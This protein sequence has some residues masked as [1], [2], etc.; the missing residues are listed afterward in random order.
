M[1]NKLKFLTKMSLKK[2]IKTKWF[3]A[4]NIII[5]ICIV[6]LL[7][8]DNIVKLFGGDFNDVTEILVI[9]NTSE[10]V[11]T[12][13]EKSYYDSS[14]YL[15]SMVN[16]SVMLYQNSE[17]EA[18]EEINADAEKILVIINDDPLN[19]L[20][21]Q[22][23][24]KSGV[25]AIISQIISVSLDAIKKD[26]ALQSLEITKE[27]LTEIN[28]SV[29]IEKINLDESASS[30]QMTDLIIGVIFPI[31]ILPFF[32]LTMF[33]VQMIGAEVN[34]EKTTKS[35]EIII[36]NVS[37]KVHFFAKVIAGNAFVLIQGL[38][39]G[40]YFILGIITRLLTG[41][42]NVN[43]SITTEVREIVNTL[44]LTGVLD[45]MVYIIP[46]TIIL[47][48]LTFVAYSLLAGVLASM[49]TNTEDYQQLQT[50]III[51]SVVGYYL[52][53]MASTFEGSTFIQIAS[54]IP[55]ISAL[56]SPALLVLG[57]ISIIDSLISLILMIITVWLLV[58]YGLRIY[59]VGILNYSQ[60]NLW[61]KMFKAMK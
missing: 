29:N 1:K 13:F 14:S 35:M 20:S 6:G 53:I 28:T 5:A 8:V 45:Q 39:I 51:I 4:A 18:K 34:E 31:L 37:P 19:Y 21:A 10:K 55:F 52:A 38:L 7:N 30:D 46:I 59:K 12:E 58:K 57:Q 24:T 3:L 41:L 42:D 26:I 47:M 49:T 16:S 27:E 40:L 44:D 22:I 61:K 48:I 36:S 25:D 50:P 2:K 56:L 9:D 17:T 33:L 54:Y 11:Y 23:I 15:S 60:N 32:M 43:S